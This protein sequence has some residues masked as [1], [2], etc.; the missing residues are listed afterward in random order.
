MSAYAS[1][2]SVLGFLT[3]LGGPVISWAQVSSDSARADSASRQL[4]LVNVSAARAAGV[5][6]GAGVVVI[7]PEALRSSP[8]PLLHEALRE[9]PFVLVRQNS[10]GEMEI[11]VRGSDSRQAAVLLD[12]VPISL[13]WD[14]RSDPSLIPITGTERIVIVRGL[15]SLLNGP[16]SLGGS[17]EISHDPFGQPAAGR[18]W[19]GAGVDQTGATVG[20]L[21][22]GKRVAE[23]G[24]GSLSLSTGVAHR[25]RDGVVLPNGAVDP[26]EKNGLRTGTDQRQTD[27]FASL[28]WN[29]PRG[30]SLGVTVS[31]YNGERGV[32]PEEHLATAA[33]FWRYPYARRVIAMFSANTG[34]F[35]T[36]LGHGSLEAGVG[37]NN[38]DFKISTYTNRT[39][40]TINGEELGDERTTTAR[41][42]VMH[43]VGP[44]TLR[45]SFTN[46]D[47]KYTETLS[48]IPAVDYQQKLTS[49]GAELEIPLF[50]RTQLAGGFVFDNAKTPLTGGRTP[51][52]QPFDNTGWRVGL[53]HELTS[54]VRLHGSASERSRFPA[55]RELYSGALN[56]FRPNPDLTPETLLGFEGG[57]TMSNLVSSVAQSTLQV[58]GFRHKLDAAVVRITLSNPTRFMR[59]N[60][61]RIESSGAEILT[62]FVFGANPDRSVSMNADATIQ[63]IKLF[64]QTANNLER[65]AENNPEQRGRVELGVPLPANVRVFAVAR[66]TGK[67]YC[68][69]AGTGKFDELKARTVSDVAA[70]RSFSVAKSG[71][72][73]ALQALV[74]LDNV[75]NTAVYDQCGLPQPGRTVR[76][77]MSV[78]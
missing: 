46:A 18:L 49:A 3:L 48:P 14:H 25:D 54:R 6:G 16:N 55:L 8:A 22:F 53:S 38:G 65:R 75:G 12:G 63:R 70:Q 42:T 64:D 73:R 34:V 58:I 30:R 28:R 68:I 43:S 71:P 69:N 39:Y 67:Q 31:G 52:Q 7:K 9:S 17:I 1:R 24:G 66:H 19:A 59:V 50:S 5:V 37:V 44:A 72:F 10:R 57:F 27:G 20:T 78:R 36:P 76:F 77:T 13:G 56:R 26:T 62:G 40:T 23:F 15:G 33:R 61:D 35:N 51:A 74:S 29:N 21:G 11:S 32:A 2:S 45:A 60:R 47:I 41:V 4:K